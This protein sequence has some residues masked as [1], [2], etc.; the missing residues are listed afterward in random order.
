MA[1]HKYLWGLTICKMNQGFVFCDIKSD[2]TRIR[3]YQN[4]L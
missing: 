4:N 3:P 2:K 1:L